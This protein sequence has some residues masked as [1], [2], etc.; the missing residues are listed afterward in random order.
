MLATKLSNDEQGVARVEHALAG[1]EQYSDA[2]LW[3][4][5]R[6]QLS[7][8]S[9]DRS[10][11]LNDKQ[12]SEGLTPAE[13]VELESLVTQY[14]WHM[15]IRSKAIALLKQRGHDISSLL[16]PLSGAA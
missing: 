12:R 3:N 4:A 2:E 1:M 5:A 16:V 8:E 7:R 9:C 15:L 11:E 6:F 14:E 10:Q 13:R